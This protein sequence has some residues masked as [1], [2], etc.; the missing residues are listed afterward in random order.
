MYAEIRAGSVVKTFE[1]KYSGCELFK[2]SVTVKG[3]EEP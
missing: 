3:A 1:A 2:V